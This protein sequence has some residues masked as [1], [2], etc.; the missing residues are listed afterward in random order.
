MIARAAIRIYSQLKRSLI[1]E[2]INNLKKVKEINNRNHNSNN[3]KVE[4]EIIKGK[5]RI[6]SNNRRV[7]KWGNKIKE[8]KIREE[9]E[10]K[11]RIGIEIRIKTKSEIISRVKFMNFFN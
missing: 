3:R 8:D 6:N 2:A 5:E 11:R 4:W 7:H 1:K 9:K 10:R